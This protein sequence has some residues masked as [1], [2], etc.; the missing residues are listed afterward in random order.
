MKENKE[1]FYVSKE[2][3]FKKHDTTK[4]TYPQPF[5]L[6][7]RNSNSEN[8]KIFLFIDVKISK[9][10]KGRKLDMDKFIYLSSSWI[11]VR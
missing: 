5:H 10:K 6:N 3:K 9:S 7:S 2:E 4:I 1:N 8:K 11:K